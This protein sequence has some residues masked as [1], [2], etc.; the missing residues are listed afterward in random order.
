MTFVVLLRILL[1]RDWLTALVPTVFMVSMLTLSGP[2]PVEAIWFTLIWAPVF[3]M[4]VRFGLLALIAGFLFSSIEQM[5]R[6]WDPA[7][8]YFPYVAIGLAL[9]LLPL[10]YCFFISMGGKKLIRAELL[11]G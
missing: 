7:S 2:N 1:R 11:D 3:F 4:A 8:W 6:V 10:L 9:F 5:V